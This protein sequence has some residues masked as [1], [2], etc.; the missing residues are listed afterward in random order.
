MKSL[1]YFFF[2]LAPLALASQ[3]KTS[4]VSV[5]GATSKIKEQYSV[6][7]NKK[8]IKHGEYEYIYSGKTLISGVYSNGLKNGLWLYTPSKSFTIVGNYLE[9][10]KTGKWVYLN[11]KDTLSILQYSNGELEGEQLGFY[12][13]GTLASYSIFEDD[14]QEGITKLYYPN[15]AIKE[16]ANYKNGE[17]DGES[18]LYSA[19]GQLVYRFTFQNNNVVAFEKG[20]DTIEKIAF[21]GV[22]S[23]GT[24]YIN[25]FTAD[26]EGNKH[27]TQHTEF[28]DS[29][30]WGEAY[31]KD[32]AGNYTFKGQFSNGFLSGE[33]YFY[34]SDGTVYDTV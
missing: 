2:V 3:V 18:L 14:E 9:D 7:K 34:K 20:T 8:E 33:W 30:K 24:G 19:S 10:E 17:L 5:E 32:T 27:L 25:S 1:F 22:L 16:I 4:K 11:E 15:G 12:V 29:V 23:E 13:D 6:I 28:R 21:E 31:G 26:S